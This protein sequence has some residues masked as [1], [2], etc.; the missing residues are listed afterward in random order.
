MNEA[1]HIVIT[2]FM[3]SGKTTVGRALAGLLG[4]SIMDLD[5]VISKREQRS[6]CGII[7]Q[8]GEAYFRQRETSALAHVLRSERACVIALGGGAWIMERNR[9]LIARRHCLTAWL[10]APFE[11]CWQRITQAGNKER[12]FAGDYDQARRLYQERR[13]LYGMAAIRIGANGRKTVK[14]LAGEIVAYCQR[15]NSSPVLHPPRGMR[16]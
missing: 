1:S 10:D 12:P 3:A 4:C 11:L 15:N 8:E 5:E 6:I 16:K 9:R 2:G 13:P 7:E 14:E